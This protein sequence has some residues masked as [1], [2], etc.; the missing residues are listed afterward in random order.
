MCAAWLAERVGEINVATTNAGAQ[1]GHT[2]QYLDGRKFICFHLPTIGVV[3]EDAI[4]YINAGSIIDVDQLEAELI[5]CKVERKRVFIHPRAAVI[6]QANRDAEKSGG[7]STEKLASTQKGV[8]AAIAD[9]VMRR[10]ILAKDEPR[11][12]EF[13][14]MLDLNQ[15][16]DRGMRVTVEVPQGHDLSINHGLAYPSCTSRDCWVGSGLS[17]A[18]VHPSFLD[19]TAMVVRTFP[20]RVGGIYNELGEQLGESGPFY[21]D[22]EELKWGDFPG[23][24]PERTTVTKR[25]RRISTWSQQQYRRALRLNRPD[26]VMLNF[27]NYLPDEDAFWSR[28][29][30]MVEDEKTAGVDP[31]HVFGVGPCT[32]EVINDVGRTASWLKT[33]K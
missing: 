33:R 5:A 27:V 1:A 19:S 25:V 21:P 23:V 9:K 10:A 14:K 13:I 22:S 28:F 2:T 26:F 4:C 31:I 30:T 29:R 15:M 12:A 17:D 8:G 7:S 18:G 20:I 3:Q 16:L 32:E 11:L 6:T 24:E